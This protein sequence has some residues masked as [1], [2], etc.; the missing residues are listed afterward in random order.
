MDYFYRPDFSHKPKENSPT[1]S[2]LTILV[3]NWNHRFC[4]LIVQKIFV[5][6]I[7]CVICVPITSSIIKEVNSSYTNWSKYWILYETIFSNVIHHFSNVHILR[8]M[9]C[10][11]YILFILGKTVLFETS[12]ITFL[13]IILR[14]L[15]FDFYLFFYV[16]STTMRAQHIQIT[17]HNLDILSKIISKFYRMETKGFL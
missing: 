8:R 17:Y 1:I 5:S 13:W 11:I 9:G 12:L 4:R 10:A 2:I 15:S 16:I 7:N 6:K 3:A 14:L